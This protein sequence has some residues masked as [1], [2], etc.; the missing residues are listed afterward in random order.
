MKPL[1]FLAPFSEW[2]MRSGVLLFVILYYLKVIRGMNFDSM[3]FWLS[4]GFLIFSILLFVGGFLRNTT[5][6][7]VSALILTILTG[8]QAAIFVKLGIDYNFAVFVVLGSVL[9]HF[10]SKGNNN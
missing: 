2:L 1:K 6:T 4:I 9:V 5:L 7:V 3:M 10:L 8:Y